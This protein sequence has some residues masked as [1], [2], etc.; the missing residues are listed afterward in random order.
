[1]KLILLEGLDDIAI[2]KTIE[3]LKN[4]IRNAEKTVESITFPRYNEKSGMFIKDHLTGFPK[5]DSTV[6]Y[7]FDDILDISNVNELIFVYDKLKGKTSLV[8]VEKIIKEERVF[9]AFNCIEETHEIYREDSDKRFLFYKSRYNKIFSWGVKASHTTKALLYTIDRNIWFANNKAAINN[10]DYL[11]VNRSYLSNFLYRTVEITKPEDFLEYIISIMQIE[12]K[13]SGLDDYEVY[14]YFI[15][16]NN[17]EAQLDY[18]RNYYL[19]NSISK[20]NMIKRN[21][22]YIKTI[23]QNYEHLKELM[24][25]VSAEYPKIYNKYKNFIEMKDI[26]ITIFSYINNLDKLAYDIFQEVK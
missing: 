8:Q 25:V 24:K 13:A 7:Y 20:A 22:Q 16:T 17:L 26:N 1:M 21:E 19:D 12:V 6:F 23:W 9:I 3:H 10:L 14:P 11:I 18:V 5:I 2:N 4:Q 15:K